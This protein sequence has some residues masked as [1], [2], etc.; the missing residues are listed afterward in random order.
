LL[1]QRGASLRICDRPFL[2]VCFPFLSFPSLYL[3][4]SSHTAKTIERSCFSTD[5][6]E[7]TDFCNTARRHCGCFSDLTTDTN[8]KC[9]DSTQLNSTQRTMVRNYGAISCKDMP[10]GSLASSYHIVP[11]CQLVVIETTTSPLKHHQQNLTEDATTRR[12]V[13]ILFESL[14]PGRN[15]VIY[16]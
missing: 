11:Y 1:R 7:T 9:S 2:Y 16:S 5:T 4:L 12:E 13:N 3:F 14:T 15:V 6:A 8:Y 10:F